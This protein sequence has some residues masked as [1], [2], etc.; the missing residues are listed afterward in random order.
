[1]K[2]TPVNSIGVLIRRWAFEAI[3]Q[4]RRTEGDYA[5]TLAH[6]EPGDTPSNISEAIQRH[7]APKPGARAKSRPIA[8]RSPP[9]SGSGAEELTREHHLMAARCEASTRPTPTGIKWGARRSP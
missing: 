3:S 2:R 4:R 6:K 9:D 8:V 5:I 1:M 7:T